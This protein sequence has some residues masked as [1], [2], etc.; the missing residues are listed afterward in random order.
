MYKHLIATFE[1]RLLFAWSPGDL[2]PHLIE[3][4]N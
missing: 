3:A 2:H 4:A 1:G